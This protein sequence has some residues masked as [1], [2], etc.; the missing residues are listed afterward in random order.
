MAELEGTDPPAEARHPLPRRGLS[1]RIMRAMSAQMAAQALRIVQQILLVPLFLRAW[2]IDIYTDWLVIG[3]AVSF[4][5]ILDGGMQAY[6]SGLLQER[7]M[8]GDTAGYRRAARSQQLRRL[9][10]RT[11]HPCADR[12]RCLCDPGASRRQCPDLAADRD[13]RLAL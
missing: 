6:F 1:A 13:G 9:A 5:G 3:A 2:G 11:G 10:C 8:K 4:A 12:T 7:L